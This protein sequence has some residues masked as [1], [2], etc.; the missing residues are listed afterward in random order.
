LVER[1][2]R[3]VEDLGGR[4]PSFQRLALAAERGIIRQLK[5]NMLAP[6][7][8]DCRSGTLTG[9]ESRITRAA[10]IRHA[11]RKTG[12]SMKRKWL[13]LLGI[14]LMAAATAALGLLGNSG[15][16]FAWGLAAGAGIGAAIS[17][18]TERVATK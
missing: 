10:T 14:S 5:G 7:Q 6:S 18:F 15:T 1:P 16:D 12:G 13:L 17:W 4:H 11:R 3:G 2:G 9:L 8:P